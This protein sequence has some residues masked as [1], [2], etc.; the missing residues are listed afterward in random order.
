MLTI[1]P[2]PIGN[3]EDISFRALR[4]LEEAHTIFAE[5]TRVTK[6]LL[7][8]L[9]ERYNITPCYQDIISMH[10]HN[11]DRVIATL[12][13]ELFAQKV[14]YV[15][16][17]GMPSVSDPASKLIAFAQENAIE[18]DVLPGANALL[19]AYVASGFS[20]TSFTF[21]GFLPHKSKERLSVLERILAQM[22]VG[23]LYEA[24]HRILK[25]LEEI[26]IL[27]SAREIFVAKELS[28]KHQRFFKGEA[29]QILKAIENT[30]GEWVVV[31]AG[32]KEVRVQ[33]AIS[34][35]DILNLDIPKKEQAKL[36]AKIENRSVKAC[37]NDLI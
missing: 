11:E 27:D 23:I 25:L 20:Q 35:H 3:L 21:H 5:D 9:K 14:I 13:K 36:I 12:S 10:T 18:Y 2:T 7:L 6:K 17:A 28:K 15:S 34:K 26:D 16:D 8:L 30:K 32:A 33:G 1:V 37:Y 22:S 4:A 19:V 29:K 31:I 24:P